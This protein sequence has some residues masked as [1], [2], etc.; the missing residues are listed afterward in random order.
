M[1]IEFRV[2]NFRSI[3][4]EQ[5]LSLVA[6]RADK[7]LSESLIKADY[8]GMANTDYL[9]GAALYGHNASGKTNLLLAFEFL[10]DL[11]KNSAVG[12]MPG[13]A[14]GAE[15]F[16]L[17]DSSSA[18]PCRFE[19]SFIASGVRYLFGAAVTS[20]RV[21]EEFL[22]S[23]PKGLPQ[24]WYR[25]TYDPNTR[26][27]AW[28]KPSSFF[29]AD[30]SLR[31]K[32][33]ENS[34]FLS[35]GPQ[36]N[37]SQ[38]TPVFQWFNNHVRFLKLSCDSALHPL[39]TAKRLSSGKGTRGIM[40]LLRSADIAIIEAVVS[41]R[42]VDLIGLREQLPPK[43]FA[44]LTND[45]NKKISLEV[46]LSH[47]AGDHPPVQLNFAKEESAGTRRYFALAGPWMD[48]LENGVLVFIDEIET[49]LHP[50]LVKELVRLI[51]DPAANP[52]GAQII[53]TT[54]SPTLLDTN[55]LRRDQIW[56]TEK[57]E[58]GTTRLYPLTDYQP[59]KGE[60]IS[61]GYL[62]GRYGGVPFIPEGLK[63]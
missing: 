13:E 50:L 56:F 33:R 31:P 17:D 52:K 49:S 30:E 25:R 63:I 26:A 28:D 1:L 15:P 51:Q 47:Q 5:V 53:F 54:H 20:E 42:D 36:F 12:L 44:D 57:T 11:V 40:N 8:P 24:K 27:Y 34:L 10:A 43:V 18:E 59:R 41:E 55:L 58:E 60:A 21:V 6:S 38:L 9:R 46:A 23:Y 19:V 2:A 37:D 4:E 7:D 22:V 29:R 48:I 62:A 3:R 61:K 39:Y 35:V 14:T 32:V 45:A 16:K